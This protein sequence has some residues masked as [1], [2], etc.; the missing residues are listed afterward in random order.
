MN[1]LLSHPY[2]PPDTPPYGQI[3]EKIAEALVREGHH[4]TIYSGGRSYR[5]T[6]LKSARKKTKASIE[7]RRIPLPRN[8]PLGALIYALG[9]FW[10]T[11][12]SRPDVVMAASAPPVIS[13][14]AAALGAKL[15][16]AKMIYHLQDIHP[17]V[18]EALGE[19][20]GRG[21]RARML[22]YLDGFALKR[23]ARIIVLSRDMKETLKRRSKNGL[24]I[25]VLNNFARDISPEEPGPEWHKPQ[26]IR[27]V[28][29]AG[30]L[31]RFQSLIPLSEGLLLAC[32][33]RPNLQIMWLGEG[34]E[35]ETLKAFWAEHS[36]VVF[37]P[38]MSEAQ[39]LWLIQE[40]DI[41]I[42]SL[43]PGICKTS[44]PSKLFTYSSCNLPVLALVAPQSE[45]AR[46][47]ETQG[48]GAVAPN[49]SPEAIAKTLLSLLDVPQRAPNPIA[50]SGQEKALEQW[51]ALFEELA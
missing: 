23:A 25:T 39:A 11:L 31:G 16:G 8:R 45:L 27:R 2:F 10:M 7:I 40:A 22:R 46:D 6:P 43:E 18:S 15:C 14:L 48:L 20:L 42:V 17:E 41:G 19:K 44:Y 30:N 21:W 35:L 51:C 26:G 13:G 34:V 29:F 4:V 24:T 33:E 5:G 28:I 12:K 49:K 32:A 47:I 3:L 37:T 9:L 38:Q 1:I 36:Q 50:Q